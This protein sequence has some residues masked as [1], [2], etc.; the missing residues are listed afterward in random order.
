[1]NPATIQ[2]V[3]HLTIFKNCFIDNLQNI[4]MSLIWSLINGKSNKPDKSPPENP[5]TMKF[6]MKGI[7]VFL[8]Y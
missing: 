8:A 3:E 6:R 5:K 1:M 7:R 4:L 2:T